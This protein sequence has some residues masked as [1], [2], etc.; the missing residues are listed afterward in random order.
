MKRY[1]DLTGSKIPLENWVL[2]Y[3]DIEPTYPMIDKVRDMVSATPWPI[4]WS[5]Q[6]PPRL[7]QT[8]PGFP[9]LLRD[10]A[11]EDLPNW[12]HRPLLPNA[13]ASAGKYLIHTPAK[14][15]HQ[16][17][18]FVFPERM[19]QRWEHLCTQFPASEHRW[20]FLGDDSSRKPSSENELSLSEI[21]HHGSYI[22]DLVV[23]LSFGI[24]DTYTILH[25][26]CLQRGAQLWP[27]FELDNL[28]IKKR[29]L[30][31]QAEFLI[32]E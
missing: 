26:F 25:L 1:Y 32:L 3:E 20:I 16:K 27:E 6:I 2:T 28:K 9:I 18:L 23:D 21:I 11:R 8:D 10:D 30:M 17:V 4:L 31:N 12:C 15:H 5:H 7:L 24:M 29:M 14:D 22:P 19:E 13:K